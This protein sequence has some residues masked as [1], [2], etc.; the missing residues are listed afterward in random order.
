MFCRFQGIVLR[1]FISHMRS[2]V[3]Q[4]MPLKW[5]TRAAAPAAA[6]LL[7]SAAMSA[8]F[9]DNALPPEAGVWFDDT[10]KGAVRIEPC[11][12]KLCGRIFWLKDLVNAKGEIL[13]DKHNP[14]PAQRTRTICGLPVLGQLQLMP[15]GGY[16]G[17]WVYDPKV[18]KSYTVAIALNGRDVLTVTGYLGVK[19]L[20]KNLTWTRA[21]TELPNCAAA[22][23]EV[24]AGPAKKGGG[25][26]L[27]WAAAKPANANPAA[28]PAKKPATAGAAAKTPANP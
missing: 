25:E 4:K 24:K 14:D 10:G 1:K 5:L 19:L 22:P 3:M 15:E 6:A 28:K 17:G 2:F 21:K 23:S 13:T 8:S 7:A 20:G 16:D 9:A 12:A 26:T 18:G 11:G 27:P